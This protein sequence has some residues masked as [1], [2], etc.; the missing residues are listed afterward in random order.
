MT[1]ENHTLLI[2]GGARRI[3]RHLAIAAAKAGADIILHHANSPEQAEVV[4]DEI[5]ALGRKVW[6]YQADF[7]NLEQTYPIV[8]TIWNAHPFDMLINNAAIFSPLDWQSTTP[9][10]WQ[11]HLNINLTAPFFLSQSFARHLG[12]EAMG[13]I[14]NILDWRALRPADDHLPYTVSKAAL[15]ALTKSLAIAFAPNIC[16]NAIALGAILPPSDGAVHDKILQSVPAARW[17]ELDEVSQTM[18]FLL[19]GPAYITGEI[20]HV[21]GGRH[22]I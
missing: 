11:N 9:D 22:L 7:S 18:L 14:I 5:R 6:V 3:G 16:V 8:D 17:A 1:L 19:T 13:K 21:D 12:R 4:A 15:A 10:A 20:I 2:T